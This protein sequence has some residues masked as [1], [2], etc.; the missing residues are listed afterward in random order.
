VWSASYPSCSTAPGAR[1]PEPTEQEAEQ[2]PTGTSNR[3]LLLKQACPNWICEMILFT[4]GVQTKK[5][6]KASHIVCKSEAFK[7]HISLLRNVSPS[8]YYNIPISREA[9]Y[10]MYSD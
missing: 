4:V 5:E 1:A 3:T 9:K 8:D 10:C 2:V 6:L 7:R